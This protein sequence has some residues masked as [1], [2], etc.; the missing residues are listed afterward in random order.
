MS[1][2]PVVSRVLQRQ[3][4]KRNSRTIMLWVDLAIGAI[5]LGALY[6]DV[7]FLMGWPP[8]GIIL[9]R[10]INRLSPAPLPI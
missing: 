9:I 4:S 1:E 2:K 10:F 5:M 3:K 8:F 7:A 6:L